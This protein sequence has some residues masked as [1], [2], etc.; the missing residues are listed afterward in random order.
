MAAMPVGAST[1]ILLGSAVRNLRKKV[2]FPVPAFPVRNKL[3]P[4]VDNKRKAISISGLSSVIE[5]VCYEGFS[6]KAYNY[7]R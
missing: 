4:V 1:T 7:A 2:V 5:G 6:Q 3:V